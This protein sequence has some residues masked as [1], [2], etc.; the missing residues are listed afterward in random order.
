MFF[1]ERIIVRDASVATPVSGTSPIAGSFALHGV[2]FC[3]V[4]ARNLRAFLNTESLHMDMDLG[5][6]T[7]IPRVPIIMI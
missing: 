6:G 4:C 5:Q 2:F 3:K 7:T 1:N